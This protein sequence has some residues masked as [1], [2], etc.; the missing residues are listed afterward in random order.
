MPAG[1]RSIA[2]EQGVPHSLLYAVALAESGK[3]DRIR[4][5]FPALALDP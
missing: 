3:T 5:G 1:Y 2:A 4:R